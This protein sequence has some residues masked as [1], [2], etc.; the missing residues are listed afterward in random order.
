MRS[1]IM[2][3]CHWG[4]ALLDLSLHIYKIVKVLDW[5]IGGNESSPTLKAQMT[6]TMFQVSIPQL[7]EFLGPK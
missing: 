1:A 5:L 2:S 7:K 6:M 4:Y 3:T